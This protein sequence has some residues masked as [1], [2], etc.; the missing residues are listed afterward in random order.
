MGQS[1]QATIY[2]GIKIERKRH[3]EYSCQ[4]WLETGRDH[5]DFVDSLSDPICF[6]SNL[7][8][9]CRFYS[10]RLLE[11][12]MKQPI[13]CTDAR[14]WFRAMSVPQ[15]KK[16]ASG[17]TIRIYQKFFPPLEGLLQVVDPDTGNFHLILVNRFRFCR[18]SSFVCFILKSGD[19]IVSI[20][21]T[22]FEQ[23]C[24]RHASGHPIL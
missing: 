6:P 20:C 9:S 22:G 2:V 21:S 24:V 15:P 23:I 3:E 19:K 16:L 17:C 12:Q 14:S 7:A 11:A 5:A 1:Q 8:L 13:L 18:F 4:K 10:L